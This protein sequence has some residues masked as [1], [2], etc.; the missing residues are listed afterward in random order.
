MGKKL[1]KFI[2]PCS[3]F[4]AML[5]V[6]C[7]TLHVNA[8]E[9]VVKPTKE[10]DYKKF[11]PENRSKFVVVGSNGKYTLKS[12]TQYSLECKVE[13]SMK[14]LVKKG[15][16]K[17]KVKITGLNRS[18]T[19]KCQKVLKK[20]QSKPAVVSNTGTD[21]YEWYNITESGYEANDFTVSL[22]E[23]VSVLFVITDGK[24]V[25]NPDDI[26][27]NSHELYTKAKIARF[28]DNA[29]TK[30]YSKPKISYHNDVNDIFDILTIKNAKKGEMYEIDLVSNKNKIIAKTGAVKAT[31][32]GDITLNL[33]NH[34]LYRNFEFDIRK[35]DKPSIED[36]ELRVSKKP[37]S[38]SAKVGY[39][40]YKSEATYVSIG[41]KYESSA[42]GKYHVGVSQYAYEA[43]HEIYPSVK[44]ERKTKAPLSTGVVGDNLYLGVFSSDS[45]P[46]GS[47]YDYDDLVDL[48][49]LKM[50][51]VSDGIETGFLNMDGVQSKENILIISKIAQN[52]TAKSKL[53]MHFYSKLHDVNKQVPLIVDEVIFDD[54]Y[55][56]SMDLYFASLSSKK[57]VAI[58]EKL[59]LGYSEEAFDEAFANFPEDKREAYK[60]KEKATLFSDEVKSK[61]L[62]FEEVFN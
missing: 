59:D 51:Y 35:K 32:D 18:S 48:R 52:L 10:M 2:A 56:D 11:N 36:F 39:K 55:E 34:E 5:I 4:V 37:A 9:A 45:I 60:A 8:K 19:E 25:K 14:D 47:L 57:Q 41:D 43:L 28:K 49:N 23:S 50:K 3:L 24:Y 6:S 22:K 31:K 29:H 27:I 1:L 16:D 7:F 21:W 38:S 61:K 54:L 62:K 30:Q 26:R 15:R 46:Y 58:L 20:K 17:A 53:E 42:D 12:D 40:Y 13:Y 33:K 44:R